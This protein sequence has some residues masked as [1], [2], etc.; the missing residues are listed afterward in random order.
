MALGASPVA[1]NAKGN[2]PI[3]HTVKIGEKEAA[4][5]TAKKMKTS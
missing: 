3:A 2:I 1:S 4:K 5:M